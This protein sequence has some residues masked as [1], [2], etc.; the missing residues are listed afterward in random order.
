MNDY[1]YSDATNKKIQEYVEQGYKLKYT[2]N[3][4]GQQIAVVNPISW[5]LSQGQPA[6]GLTGVRSQRSTS[7]SNATDYQD[8]SAGEENADPT[9]QD[10]IQQWQE[11]SLTV[12]QI[13]AIVAAQA[14]VDQQ[15]SNGGGGD[16]QG[17]NLGGI[18]LMGL[19]LML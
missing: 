5:N 13:Q 19:L 1:G 14:G 6:S 11:G 8:G 4:L 15:E 16:Q 9:N 17:F 7:G 12:E 2:T 10:I 18:L 3:A